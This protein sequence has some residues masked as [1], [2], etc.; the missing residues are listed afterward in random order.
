VLLVLGCGFR[1]KKVAKESDGREDTK[2]SF[3][4]MYV[5]RKMKNPIEGKMIQRYVKETKMM[6]KRRSRK[7]QA[8][9]NKRHKKNNLARVEI[10]NPVLTKRPPF[11]ET[12]LLDQTLISQ[13]LQLLLLGGRNRPGRCYG[14]HGKKLLVL[15]Y[16]KNPVDGG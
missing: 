6:N 1:Q 5:D 8:S 12:L 11:S 7:A 14:P 2:E 9:M 16:L 3:T 15:D 10:R 4:K 13:L